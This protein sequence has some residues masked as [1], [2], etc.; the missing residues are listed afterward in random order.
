M[1]KK[2]LAIRHVEIENLGMLEDL[3]KEL[4]FEVKYLDTSQSESLKEPLEVYSFLV[5]FVGYM[6]VYEASVYPFLYYEMFLIE[7]ALKKEIPLLGICLGAQLLA[8]VLG[9]E[10]YPSY[11]KEIGWREVFKVDKHPYFSQFPEKFRVFQWHR[12]TFNL[13]Y[14]ALRVFSSKHYENHGFIYNRAVGLQ[15][16]LEVDRE[17]AKLWTKNMPKN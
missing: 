6:G 16:H 2:V 4:N 7:E 3:L 14:G 1:K 17:L 9:S 8:K 15:F 5:I 10:V 13:P 12:D 11:N